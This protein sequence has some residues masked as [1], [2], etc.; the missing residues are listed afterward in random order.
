MTFEHTH[1]DVTTRKI[2]TITGTLIS[3]HKVKFQSNQSSVASPVS[4]PTGEE[5]RGSV[6]TMRELLVQQNIPMTVR[7]EE[8]SKKTSVHLQHLTR[9]HLI[10]ELFYISSNDICGIFSRIW[11][12]FI[13][14]IM[15][16]VGLGC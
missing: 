3:F 1:R 9:M 11:N 6:L 14:I 8:F 7:E 10:N 4:L 12:N 13:I 16:F 5:M 2:G 15:S